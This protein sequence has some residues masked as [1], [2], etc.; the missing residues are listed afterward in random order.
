MCSVGEDARHVLVT[1]VS[2]RAVCY[3]FGVVIRPAVAGQVVG[4]HVPV[5]PVDH[6]Y[7]SVVRSNPIRRCVATIKVEIFV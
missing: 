4:V 1:R 2:E 5:S 7:S 6:P 3:L